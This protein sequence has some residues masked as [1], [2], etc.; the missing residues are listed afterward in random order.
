MKG[1]LKNGLLSLVLVLGATLS[2]AQ[3]VI[4]DQTIIDTPQLSGV[5][6]EAKRQLA[7]GKDP[8][9][10]FDI[11]NTLMYHDYYLG[12]EPWFGT[13]YANYMSELRARFPQRADTE[14]R[15][16]TWLTVMLMNLT[17]S[18]LV[19]PEL[20]AQIRELQKAGLKVMAQTSRNVLV[21]PHTIAEMRNFGID[22]S[23]SAAFGDVFD[24]TP[25]EGARSIICS[26]GACFGQLQDKGKILLALMAR[27]GYR[28]K[29]VI[30]A[31]D[32]KK[33]IASLAAALK[34]TGIAYTGF[35]Y[36]RLDAMMKEY[37]SDG[38]LAGAR[39]QLKHY[40][41]NGK[42]LPNDK[43][44]ELSKTAPVSVKEELKWIFGPQAEPLRP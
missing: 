10:I 5:F 15:S 35:R 31:D 28:P 41:I 11:D 24:F 13:V 1:I 3:G 32:S 7:A 17:P 44:L 36:S 34:G 23:S 19:E 39:V 12:N 25:W 18:M 16:I 9:V 33:N 26:S 29:S 6:A 30:F 8:L 20:P 2:W 43:A 40:F 14:E 38:A 21:A 27:T 42:L 4:T 37:S 22:F